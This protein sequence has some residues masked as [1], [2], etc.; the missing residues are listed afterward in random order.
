[1]NPRSIV[2][3][4]VPKKLFKKIEPYGHLGEAVLAQ[5]ICGFPARKL[6]II[7]VTGTDGKTSTCSFIK[8][9]LASSGYKTA[10]MTTI[11]VDY[12]DGTGEHANPTR[13][14]TVGAFPLVKQLKKI[15]QAGAEWLV[16]ETTSHALAQHRTWGVP[17]HLAVMTNLSHEHLDYHGTFK[18]YKQAK[19]MLF[20]QCNRNRKGLKT[21]VVNADDPHGEDFS[22]A[23]KRSISYGIDGGELQAKNVKLRPSGSSYC[24]T[25]CDEEYDIQCHLPGSFN[26]YNSLAAVAV[27]MAIDLDK[28]QIELGVASLQAVEGRMTH[29]DEGQSF[30]VVVDY[31]HTPD[32]FEKLFSE[33][34]PLVK[35]RIIS[36]FGSA[37]RRDEAKRATQGEIAGKYSNV[38][39]ATEEDDRDCDGQEILQQ[40][41]SGVEMAGKKTGKDLLLIHKRE[42]AVAKAIKIAKAGDLVL[43]LG[44]GHEK[45]ILTS[46]PKAAEL[47]HLP[48]DDT[49]KRRVI[50]RPYSEIEVVRKIL[51]G[52]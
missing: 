13:M 26:V 31:A 33:L 45:N 36:V 48:Q 14:T 51:K 34:K 21:G 40:I 19:I 12:G 23:I 50:R 39:I 4:I 38:V 52:L 8:Q 32:S 35:G 5:I 44:K 3:K 17:Y 42:D 28:K 25:I 20:K 49:D 30:D 1:M 24:V 11:S 41:A 18:K 10:M 15:K 29:V 43:F 46:G 22:K 47:R 9:M 6:K 2:K 7:G 16:L 27:G 37:G